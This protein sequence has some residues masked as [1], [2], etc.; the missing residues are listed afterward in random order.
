MLLKDFNDN[1]EMEYKIL[2]CEKYFGTK[3]LNDELY[4]ILFSQLHKCL[5]L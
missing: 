1:S 2:L 3:I 5:N 4:L